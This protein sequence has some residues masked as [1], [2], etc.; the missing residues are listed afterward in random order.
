MTNKNELDLGRK[1]EFHCS[2]TGD[3][4]KN[5]LNGCEIVKC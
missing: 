2:D 4:K 5:Y 3:K 1:P